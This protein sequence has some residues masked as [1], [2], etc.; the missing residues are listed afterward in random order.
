[1]TSANIR[2]AP[3]IESSA[4]MSKTAPENIICRFTSIIADMIVAASS[5]HNIGSSG[6]SVN[7][8]K[9]NVTI[10]NTKTIII[11]TR[12]M[13]VQVVKSIGNT[14]ETVMSR[15]RIPATQLSVRTVITGSKS[16]T[17]VQRMIDIDST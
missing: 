13:E 4:H 12:T 14:R 7:S 10:E 8:F 16:E 1:M 9:P 15:S 6:M 11:N 2:I 3:R 17:T 5:D